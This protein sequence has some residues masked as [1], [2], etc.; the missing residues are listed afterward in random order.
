MDSPR[1]RAARTVLDHLFTCLVT[2][3]APYLAFTAEEAWIARNGAESSVHLQ[4]FPAI[5]AGWRADAVAAK[6]EH[7]RNV[8]RVVTGALEVERA[9]KRIGSSLQAHPHVFIADAALKAAAAGCDMAEVCITSA[10]TLGDG[11]AP[12]GAF[13]LPDVPGMAVVPGLAEGQKCSRCWNVLPDVGSHS[14]HPD[15]CARCD[16]AMKDFA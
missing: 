11:P 4:T 7:I 2:W 3:L 5:P 12:E 15:M 16:A 6:W 13:I 14:G 10:C 8:R 1:R 9:E